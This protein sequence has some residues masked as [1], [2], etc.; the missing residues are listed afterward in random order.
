M[1]MLTV[2]RNEEARLGLMNPCP[3]WLIVTGGGLQLCRPTQPYMCGFTVG[4]S[5]ATVTTTSV[6][7]WHSMSPT[8]GYKQIEY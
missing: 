7:I 2:I 1:V 4:K 8:Y 5:V 6:L 3:G